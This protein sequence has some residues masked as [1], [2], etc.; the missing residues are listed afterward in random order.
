MEEPSSHE[1]GVEKLAGATAELLTAVELLKHGFAVSWPFGD[2]E[3]Y[4]LIGDSR[5][6]LTRL[7]VKSSSVK[8][9]HGTYR[10]LFAR[11]GKKL[12]YSKNDADYFV[13]VLMYSNGPAFYVIPIEEVKLSARFWE[14]G[15]H[16]LQAAK[17]HVCPYEVFRDRWDLLR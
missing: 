6:R 16:P 1:K 14:P 17:W 15:A 11:G 13:V 10:V 2:S 3:G 4:D 7:Q 9:K 12:P 8:T 5:S